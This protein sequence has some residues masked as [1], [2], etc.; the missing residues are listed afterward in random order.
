[1]EL[2]CENENHHRNDTLHLYSE[3][4]FTYFPW[5]DFP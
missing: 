2:S 5:Y 3:S 4:L 1:M